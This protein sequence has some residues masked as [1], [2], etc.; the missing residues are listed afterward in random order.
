M[1]RTNRDLYLAIEDLSRQHSEC[2]RSL[3]SYL[4]TVLK[5][6]VAFRESQ[7]LS[8]GEFFKLIESGFT[9][10]VALF[11]EAWRD[12]YSQLPT[13]QDGYVGWEATVIRQIVDLREMDENG[14][15]Q[16]EMRYFGVDSPRKARWFNF[17]PLTYLECAA[18][19]SFGGW[20]SGD[21]TGRDYVPGPV[22][23]TAE[24][25]STRVANPEELSEP[26]F[27]RPA[28]SWEQ[29]TDFVVCGQIYE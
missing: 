29:F 16:N 19:G 24:D 14:T 25:G 23:V 13:E 17:E 5:C 12:R 28:V 22:V 21:D 18:A 27:E 4:L 9:G 2:A 3:E 7:S 20:E 1:L 15:L 26:R 11:D 6:S 10:E 8:L